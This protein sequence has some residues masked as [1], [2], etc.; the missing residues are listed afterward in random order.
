MAFFP[1]KYREDDM[2]LFV[3]KS[4]GDVPPSSYKSRRNTTNTR[5]PGVERLGIMTTEQIGGKFQTGLNISRVVSGL[6]FCCQE[7]W[8]LEDH[9]VPI[10]EGKLGE[11][12]LRDVLGCGVG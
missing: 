7:S 9:A 2:L 4:W 3:M 11:L 1:P 6:W 12:S 5:R 10:V 8:S